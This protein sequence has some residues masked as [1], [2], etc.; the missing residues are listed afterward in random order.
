MSRCATAKKNSKKVIFS[1]SGDFFKFES[2]PFFIIREYVGLLIQRLWVRIPSVVLF[3]IR[4][5][6]KLLL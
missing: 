4:A 2:S 5:Q 3:K 6:K 1:A